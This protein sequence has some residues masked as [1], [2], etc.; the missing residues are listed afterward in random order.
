VNREYHKWFSPR[1]QRDMEL[2]RFG[3]AGSPVLVFPT[4]QG[5][6]FD[7]KNWGL[8]GALR[9][10]IYA[11]HL[12]LYCVD[13]IDSE[14]LYCRHCP[15][16]SRISRH[17]QY[18]QYILQEVIPLM[19]SHA[20]SGFLIVHGCSIGAFHAMN[21]VLR[22]PLLF[23]KVVALSGRYDLTQPVGTFEDLFRGEYNQDIYFHTPLHF[24]PGLDSQ[25]RLEPLRRMQIV[26]AVGNQ[27]SF[28]D[29]NRRLSH[30]LWVKGMPHQL[31]VWEGEAHR[32]SSWRH[33][34]SHYL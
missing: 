23:G 12:Q 15:A 1:L 31:A 34:V 30:E 26:L 17:N 27:D 21:L 33:M 3:H 29:S 7:Y 18:E 6:F 10:S 9:C 16:E 19:R 5:R 28:F 13:S 8:V 4:R 24:L 2:L 20:P 14:S 11:G 32:A 25:E 22:H